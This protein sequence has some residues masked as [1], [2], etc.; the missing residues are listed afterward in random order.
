MD[1]DP[2]TRERIDSLVKSN[3]VM[4]FMKGNRQAP[5]CGF[6]A[7][8]VQILDTIVS[9]YDTTDVLQDPIRRR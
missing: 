3:D 9:D 2:T 1:L 6:S 7:T 5:Q 8:V 4:L